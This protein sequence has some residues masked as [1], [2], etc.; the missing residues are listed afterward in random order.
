MGVNQKGN[1]F[2]SSPYVEYEGEVTP[3]V[4][5]L[6]IK[7]VQIHVD[8]LISTGIAMN[9]ST[10][11]YDEVAQVCGS[12]PTYL[13]AGAPVRVVQFDGEIGCPCGGTH[14][15][16]SSD[17]VK[18]TITKLEKPSKGKLRVKYNVG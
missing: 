10:L 3:E 17:I 16:S 1:H 13:P 12:T 8:K 14:V 9:V 11:S 5:A 2:P 15:K 6:F 7:N 4:K 18:L